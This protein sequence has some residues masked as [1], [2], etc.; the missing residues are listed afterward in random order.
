MSSSNPEAVTAN[1]KAP[2]VDAATASAATTGVV[3]A[4]AAKTTTMEPEMP[5]TPS[6]QS[7][8]VDEAAPMKF[9]CYQIPP[10]VADET[11]SLAKDM[12]FMIITVPRESAQTEVTN[13]DDVK[14]TVTE[15]VN[16]A[17][18]DIAGVPT[19]TFT[20]TQ[21][22]KAAFNE[23][24]PVVSRGE[25]KLIKTHDVRNMGKHP[26]NPYDLTKGSS[27]GTGGHTK[28]AIHKQPVPTGLEALNLNNRPNPSVD[29]LPPHKRPAM[30]LADMTERWDETTKSTI[31]E[32]R[33]KPEDKPAGDRS[34]SQSH[35]DRYQ[36]PVGVIRKQQR[37]HSTHQ[38]R[39]GTSSRGRPQYRQHSAHQ[40]RNESSPDL[41][42]QRMKKFSAEPSP[43]TP[44][45]T[46]MTSTPAMSAL[47]S[48]S[49][50]AG[51]AEPPK[52]A[53]QLEFD[54][55]G[56][57]YDFQ[58]YQRDLAKHGVKGLS[59]SRWANA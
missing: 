43:K 29:D 57:P 36:S 55:D 37:Q 50:V 54:E 59:S 38:S 21:Q 45:P 16:A 44:A 53:K 15:Q 40:K 9:L 56:L 10:H 31:V 48:T 17:V 32:P 41:V 11:E 22:I 34:L 3:T 5:H 4:A 42:F 2:T 49:N 18:K 7:S 39:P 51:R 20:T 19:K 33:T 1:G 47:A 52:Q 23:N 13:Y 46:P 30:K 8:N 25:A 28:G 6:G 12:G 14:A 24:N 27:Q 58:E 26:E 35:R